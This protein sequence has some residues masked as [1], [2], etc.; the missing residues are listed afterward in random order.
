MKPVLKQR[1]TGRLVVH[2]LLVLY[3]LILAYIVGGLIFNYGVPVDLF[4]GLS[5]A[6]LFFTIGQALYEIGLLNTLVFFLITSA[7]GFLVE[8]L[9]TSTGLL[10]G[11]Y[12]YGDFLGPKI[13]GV[14]E[15]VPLIWFVIVY[16][17]FS[18]VYG[19]SARNVSAER[20][21]SS[22]HSWLIVAVALASFG[23]MA[24]DVIV[25]PMF[26]SYGYWV[27]DPSNYGPKLYGV[28]ASNFVGWFAVAF[29]MFLLIAAAL[30]ATKSSFGIKRNNSLDSRIVYVL[31]LIDGGVANATLGNYLAILLGVLAMAGF[32]TGSLLLA[33]Q[34]TIHSQAAKVRQTV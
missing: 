7:V 12:T 15:V 25:D 8:I 23:A 9:G 17:C 10:F 24:W 32:L 11:K 5:F 14:P 30:R 3:A 13:Y 16:I 18:V 26:S 29:L 21:P 2:A 19:A 22:S 1:D 4:F 6:L 33:K 28:P 34:S 27:W 31:L 20:S